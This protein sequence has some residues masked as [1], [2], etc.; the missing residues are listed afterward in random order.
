MDN[1]LFHRAFERLP[2]CFTQGVFEVCEERGLTLIEIGEGV[3]VDDIRADTVHSRCST[4][5]RRSI[6]T[7]ATD[8][9]LLRSLP[10]NS[11]HTGEQLAGP[12]AG[13]SLSL[14]FRFCT[15]KRA[16]C[17]ARR[18]IGLWVCVRI[19]IFFTLRLHNIMEIKQQLY[20]SHI[21]QVSRNLQNKL[22]STAAILEGYP[23]LWT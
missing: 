9:H 20:L 13:Y 23:L 10:S 5:T 4:K 11:R 6:K 12:M 19:I 18:I 16:Q 2:P 1:I 14:A 3:G 7:L 22:Y 21:F 8:S 17:A 15:I